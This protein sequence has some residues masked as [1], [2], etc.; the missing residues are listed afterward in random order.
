LQ[1]TGDERFAASL[2]LSL[3]QSKKFSR[4]EAEVAAIME[5][6][7]ENWFVAGFALGIAEG[8]GLPIQAPLVQAIKAEYTYLSMNS[9]LFGRPGANTLRRRFALL[10]KTLAG[11]GPD[12]REPGAANSNGAEQ[13]KP[14]HYDT[15][16]YGLALP[17][18][19]KSVL[20]V[21][22]TGARLLDINSGAAI[23]NFYARYVE[24][25]AVTSNFTRLVTGSQNGAVTLWDIT[26]GKMVRDFSPAEQGIYDVHA[27]AFSPDG[28]GQHRPTAKSAFGGSAWRLT[29]WPS[30][31][32][33]D[34]LTM[35]AESDNSAS[36]PRC[37][38]FYFDPIL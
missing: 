24:S 15:L 3:A 12:R 18:D 9:G 19:G 13:R 23:R 2:I 38:V 30:R 29:A 25:W 6:F 32:S 8:K 10:S 28:C 33:F 4:D 35:T 31:R 21:T 37:G 34:P 17:P 36:L 27:L 14:N 5:K 22:R 20:V 26:S 1:A 11:A 7:P 16:L